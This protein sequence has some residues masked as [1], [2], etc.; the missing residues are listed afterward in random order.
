MGAILLTL[1]GN[2]LVAIVVIVA[3]AVIAWKVV[4]TV[5]RTLSAVDRDPTDP[6]KDQQQR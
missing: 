5:E 2:P 4:T 3:A 6:P 1:F